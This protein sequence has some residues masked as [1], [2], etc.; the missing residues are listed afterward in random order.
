MYASVH[1][2]LSW[3]GVTRFFVYVCVSDCFFAILFEIV[4]PRNGMD[5]NGFITTPFRSIRCSDDF[6]DPIWMVGWRRSLFDWEKCSSLCFKNLLLSGLKYRQIKKKIWQKNELTNSSV[7]GVLFFLF[8][9]NNFF[10]FV[11]GLWKP[12]KRKRKHS[13]FT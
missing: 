2:S 8:S 9:L 1:K 7:K 4:M 13:K 10:P 11:F 12:K 6:C 3:F 5:W